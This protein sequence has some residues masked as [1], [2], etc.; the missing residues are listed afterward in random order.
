LVVL[1]L[2]QTVEWYDGDPKH[3]EL[4]SVPTGDPEFERDAIALFQVADDLYTHRR[5]RLE[6]TGVLS[7]ISMKSGS[8]EP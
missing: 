3:D 8:H 1:G 6:S 5:Y 7:M 4:R 2:R